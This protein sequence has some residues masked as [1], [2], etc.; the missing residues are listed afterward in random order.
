MLINVSLTHFELIFKQYMH[1][2]KLKI[3]E[4]NMLMIQN[5]EIQKSCFQYIYR[6]H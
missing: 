1:I 3:G 4:N 6:L 5:K 2:N